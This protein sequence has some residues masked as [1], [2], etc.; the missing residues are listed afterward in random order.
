MIGHE[1][2]ARIL[3]SCKSIYYDSFRSGD[4]AVYSRL[5]SASPQEALSFFLTGE[6]RDD[7]EKFAEF[8]QLL[9][10]FTVIVISLVMIGF[11]L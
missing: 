11:I 1:N 7:V 9:A 2:L 4:P 8:G 3:S 6:Y 5:A 10:F